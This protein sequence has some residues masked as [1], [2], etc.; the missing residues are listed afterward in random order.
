MQR[1]AADIIMQWTSSRSKH[2]TQR[3]SSGGAAQRSGAS[4][5]A[6]AA[7]PPRAGR[8]ARRWPAGGMQRPR[9]RHGRC[10]SAP[11]GC[12][13]QRQAG[14]WMAEWR[15]TRHAVAKP[16]DQQ[17]RACGEQIAMAPNLA[18]A[19]AAGARWWPEWA[20]SA[21][22]RCAVVAPATAAG[23]RRQVEQTPR[24]PWSGHTESPNVLEKSSYTTSAVIYM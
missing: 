20:A 9:S 5:A 22:R 18:P 12:R 7:T 16:G 6:S 4:A 21:T 11:R 23:W 14:A 10:C 19:W 17:T 3:T 8:A 24:R 2:I 13:G 15:P 1:Y